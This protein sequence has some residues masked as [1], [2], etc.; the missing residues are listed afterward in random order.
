MQISNNA[1]K[2]P[3]KKMKKNLQLAKTVVVAYN[4]HSHVDYA[5]TDELTMHVC[6]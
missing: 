6:V 4:S 1:N 2:G 5:H 3:P